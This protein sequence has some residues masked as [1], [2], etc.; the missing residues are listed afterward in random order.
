MKV[1]VIRAKGLLN[2]Y[3][4]KKYKIKKIQEVT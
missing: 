2:F 4:R 1:V 3:L